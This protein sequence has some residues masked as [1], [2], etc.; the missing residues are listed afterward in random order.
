MKGNSMANIFQL[1]PS[2]EGD[3]MIFVQGITKDMS[4]NQLQF[5]AT[6]YSARR[7]DPLLILITALLGFVVLAGIHRFILGHIGLGF[8]YLFTGGICLIGT[9]IDIVNYKRLSF[10]YNQQIAQQVAM[11]SRAAG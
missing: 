3:E 6:L 10:E 5:F 9:I 4:D 2:L 8:L 1:L 11:M 7:K